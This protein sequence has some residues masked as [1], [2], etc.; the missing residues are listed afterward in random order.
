MSKVRIGLLLA[1]I[2]FIFS[3]RG[4]PAYAG[5]EKVSEDIMSH[6]V[7]IVLKFGYHKARIGSGTLIKHKGMTA[8]LTAQHVAVVPYV[9]AGGRLEACSVTG[10]N[11]CVDLGGSF[12]MDTD[13]SVGTDW[14]IYPVDKKAF[15]SVVPA[16]IRKTR[17]VVG[18]AIVASGVPQGYVP[19]LSFGHVAS[20]W[21][22][23]GHEIIGVD[24]F[25]YFGSSG[26]GVYDSR[27][28]LI[29][30]VSAIG[31]GRWGPLEDKVYVT[32]VHN[33]PM[34]N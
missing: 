19:W 7:A 20:I 1:V 23:E 34:F 30:V 32:P 18:E 14:A 4:L 33:I 26:G 21:K 31:S 22:E 9:M 2:S 24:G 15:Q 25:A 16:R 8:V 27:G 6:S 10:S 13:M 17:A 12:M 29:G 11:E 5:T 3:C 28:R